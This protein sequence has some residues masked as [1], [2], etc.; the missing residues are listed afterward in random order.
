MI[1]QKPAERIHSF[2]GSETARAQPSK[3]PLFIS[4]ASISSLSK[5]CRK[6][7]NWLKYFLGSESNGKHLLSDLSFNLA[8]RANHLLP[9]VVSIAIID[10]YDLEKKLAIAVSGV[11]TMISNPRLI[12]LVFGGQETDF[13]GISKDIY[14][15]SPLFRHYLDDCNNIMISLGLEGLYPAI[16]PH[17][18]VS[19][20]V[21]LHLALFS[22][23][24]ASAK[25]WIDCGLE[26]TVVIGHSFNQLTALCT[27]G[28][29]SLPDALKLV[30]GRASLTLRYWES[31]RG[32][33]IFLQAD[34]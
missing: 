16:F 32:F 33:M 28:T 10:M 29:L 18:P 7:A 19:N 1:R 13:V 31:E 3:Y 8:D 27:S 4:A 17:T 12:V 34:R 15:S 2:S 5:Y 9:H 24:Y 23:Q 21:R 22:V 25:A 14:Q 26:F 11:H 6:L 30:A 20:L